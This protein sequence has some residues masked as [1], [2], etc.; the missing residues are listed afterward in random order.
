[1]NNVDVQIITIDNQKYAFLDNFSYNDLKIW[2]GRTVD[3]IADLGDQLLTCIQQIFNRIFCCCSSDE[4]SPNDDQ[5]PLLASNPPLVEQENIRVD[6]SPETNPEVILSIDPAI[7]SAKSSSCE[8]VNPTDSLSNIP[9]LAIPENVSQEIRE[10]N[11]HE[12]ELLIVSFFDHIIKYEMKFPLSLEYSHILQNAKIHFNCSIDT[13]CPEDKFLE[14]IIECLIKCPEAQFNT[15]CEELKKCD[16]KPKHELLSNPFSIKD[17]LKLLGRGWFHWELFDQVIKLYDSRPT[18]ARSLFQMIVLNFSTCKMRDSNILNAF[19]GH[20]QTQEKVIDFINACEKLPG[21]IRDDNFRKLVPRNSDNTI[22]DD[23]RKYGMISQA[24]EK[25]NKDIKRFHPINEFAFA[26][27]PLDI[28]PLVYDILPLKELFKMGSVFSHKGQFKAFSLESYLTLNLRLNRIS[29]L[30]NVEQGGNKYNAPFYKHLNSV[31]EHLLNVNPKPLKGKEKIESTNGVT[32]KEYLFELI[33]DKSLPIVGDTEATKIF[34][35]NCFE[36]FFREASNQELLS[37]MSQALGYAKSKDCTLER[38]EGNFTQNTYMFIQL[39]KVKQNQE[40]L[41]SLVESEGLFAAHLILYTLFSSVSLSKS[42]DEKSEV[43]E[44]ADRLVQRFYNKITGHQQW[45]AVLKKQSSPD[46]KL[47]YCMAQTLSILKDSI[48]QEKLTKENLSAWSKET[49]KSFF[50]NPLTEKHLNLKDYISKTITQLCLEGNDPLTLEKKLTD[51]FGLIL[52]ATCD[53][54]YF[55]IDEGYLDILRDEIYKTPNFS[56]AHK[57][58]TKAIINVCCACEFGFSHYIIGVTTEEQIRDFY[59]VSVK[60]PEPLKTILLTNLL[61][62]VAAKFK[63]KLDKEMN[64]TLNL[65]S[66][67]YENEL[68][69]WQPF[70]VQKFVSSMLSVSSHYDLSLWLQKFKDS[71]LC[72]QALTQGITMPDGTL[73]KNALDSEV[74]EQ[75]FAKERLSSDYV[76]YK[77]PIT[78]ELLLNDLLRV[79]F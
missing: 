27:L 24:F 37:L 34:I 63:S 71:K 8:D 42:S 12:V 75:A 77:K 29:D 49:L 7:E 19:I 11:I 70:K 53:S 16:F 46:Y 17:P 68:M 67:I 4:Q 62:N 26:Q 33:L 47:A 55:P 72:L 39:I 69:R 65:Y 54:K 51:F 10:N 79:P 76:G 1:M 56:D 57:I 43:T 5:I 38:K 3:F 21:S 28:P 13:G 44:I 35:S 30:I 66:W 74:I 58:A 15:I 18:I 73:L 41:I 25:L 9:L 6:I 40:R 45:E 78:F 59:D 20:I 64:G 31:L 61:S 36:L 50:Q 48:K 2:M 14:H 52:M 22:K 60:A 32:C 23:T